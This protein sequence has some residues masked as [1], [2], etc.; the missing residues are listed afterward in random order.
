MKRR[1]FEW[2]AWVW[3]ALAIALA[4]VQ[5]SGLDSTLPRLG[6][7][8]V[9]VCFIGHELGW[10]Q[11]LYR[12]VPTAGWLMLLLAA[13]V[14]VVP[15][16]RRR[17]AWRRASCAVWA[18]AL[19]A[20][21]LV[22]DLLLKE[23]W[24]RPRPRSVQAFGGPYAYYAVWEPAPTRI[25]NGSLPSGHAAAGFT[26]MAVGALA[27]R[28]RWHWALGAGM[29]AGMVIGAARV[30]Q[31][32]HFPTDIL[33]SGWVVLG[34]CLLLRRGWVWVRLRRWRRRTAAQPAGW[35]GAA[36]SG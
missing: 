25:R 8:P 10:A 6:F 35:A 34:T 2:G 29:V 12:G 18:V 23:H 22:I 36:D 27:S 31:G 20:N 14:W 13:L 21:G 19:V 32:A 24:G 17:P 7:D 3:L 16:W 11:A 1:A 9:R 5:L 33:V 26:L 28:R 15:R 4:L 30:L